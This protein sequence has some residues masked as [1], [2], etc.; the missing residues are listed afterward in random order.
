MT[1][2]GLATVFLVGAG[3]TAV[4]TARVL[5]LPGRWW[6]ATAVVAVA[7]LLLTA[8]FDSV[9][10]AAD[11]FRYDTA[12]LSGVRVL[13]MPVEDFAWPIVA[14]LVLP[15]LWELFGRLTR[16]EGRHREH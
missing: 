10:I 2:A 5:R 13:L 7:L 11:L 8:V 14:V 6:W 4:L 1:Y 16:T 9:M 15:S 12:S 3:L